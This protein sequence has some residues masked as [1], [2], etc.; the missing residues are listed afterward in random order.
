M[1]KFTFFIVYNDVQQ[2]DSLAGYE[3]RT[4]VYLD[5]KKIES[6]ALPTDFTT[7][8]LEVTWKYPL[9]KGKHKVLVKILNPD[10]RYELRNPEY[11]IFS[12]KPFKD[13]FLKE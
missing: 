10:N 7:R 13:P 6:P 12:D 11:I 3:F 2:P 9:A 4:E 5:D 8:R 1:Y